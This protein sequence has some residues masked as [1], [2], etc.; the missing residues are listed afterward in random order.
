MYQ[1]NNMRLLRVCLSE[2]I[3]RNPFIMIQQQSLHRVG[4][5]YAKFHTMSI[6]CLADGGEEGVDDASYEIEGHATVR[7][8][9]VQL[10]EKGAE[11]VVQHVSDIWVVLMLGGKGG[12]RSEEAVG[13]GL[14]IETV[15]ELAVGHAITIMEHGS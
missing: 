4:Q 13:V 1:G 7:L 14:G 12:E 2:A 9:I 5:H 15:E 11:A 6:G 10:V 3:Y 8:E